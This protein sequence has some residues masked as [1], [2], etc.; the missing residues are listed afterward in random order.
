MCLLVASKICEKDD[1]IPTVSDIVISGGKAPK[2]AQKQPKKRK[3]KIFN[4]FA[5]NF[6]LIE[7]LGFMMKD[8]DL[9]RAEVEVCLYFNWEIP[10]TTFYDHVTEFLVRGC[11]DDKDLVDINGLN[12]YS[13]STP[14]NPSTSSPEHP[15]SKSV[16]FCLLDESTKDLI[17]KKIRGFCID[18]M[19]SIL[20]NFSWNKN[21]QKELAYLVIVCSRKLCLVEKPHKA[22]LARRLG[23]QL[24]NSQK[25]FEALNLILGK[26]GV[27]MKAF[28]LLDL[29]SDRSETEGDE[30]II[31][32]VSGDAS[33]RGSRKSSKFNTSPSCEKVGGS[34]GSELPGG[35][36]TAREP[37]ISN[38]SGVSLR[39]R[40]KEVLNQTKS[41][42]K[43]ESLSRSK[44]TNINENKSN[45]K[46][47]RKRRSERRKRAGN[48]GSKR[49]VITRRDGGC[50]KIEVG[51]KK[52]ISRKEDV[53]GA[54]GVKEEPGRDED[55][56]RSLSARV[57][58]FFEASRSAHRAKHVGNIQASPLE[59]SAVRGTADRPR[60]A[61]RGLMSTKLEKLAK[62]PKNLKNSKIQNL[63]KCD[64][65]DG[66][67]AAARCRH[68]MDPGMIKNLR[69]KAFDMAGKSEKPKNSLNIVLKKR[70]TLKLQEHQISMAE[71]LPE[72]EDVLDNITLTEITSES[73]IELFPK[74]EHQRITRKILSDLRSPCF[75]ESNPQ[76]FPDEILE[77]QQTENSTYLKNKIL[78]KS[79]Q[80]EPEEPPKPPKNCIVESKVDYSWIVEPQDLSKTASKLPTKTPKKVTKMS[81]CLSRKLKELTSAKSY[82]E[83]KRVT[84][85]ISK[86]SNKKPKPFQSKVTKNTRKRAARN[87]LGALKNSSRKLKDWNSKESA[88][89]G[90]SITS[91]VFEGKGSCKSKRSNQ[92]RKSLQ[93]ELSGV[94]ADSG[95]SKQRKTHFRRLTMSPA[96]N[97]I[98][99][100][101][102]AKQS[103]LYDRSSRHERPN[104]A[105]RMKYSMHHGRDLSGSFLSKMKNR[106]GQEGQSHHQKAPRSSNHLGNL[107]GSDRALQLPERSSRHTKR[108]SYTN[109]SVLVSK[110]NVKVTKNR[111]GRELSIS[112]LHSKEKVVNNNP[113]GTAHK[114]K[115]R[116]QK[117]KTQFYESSKKGSNGQAIQ[118]ITEL[119]KIETSKHFSNFGNKPGHGA[120]QS[121]SGAPSYLNSESKSRKGSERKLRPS[122][123]QSPLGKA[124]CGN[125][126]KNYLRKGHQ[127]VGG[128]DGKPGMVS[129]SNMSSID[130]ILK[131]SNLGH[132]N[133]QMRRSLLE[134][135]QKM[136]QKLKNSQNLE[137]FH[138]ADPKRSP[139]ERLYEG[140]KIRLKRG[141]T[142]IKQPK[143]SSKE[144]RSVVLTQQK[145]IRNSLSPRLVSPD[146][147]ES[148]SKNPLQAATHNRRQTL[149][150]IYKGSDTRSHLKASN[151]NLRKSTMFTDRPLYKPLVFKNKDSSKLNQSSHNFTARN[152]QREFRNVG[153]GAGGFEEPSPG[154]LHHQKQPSSY[155]NSDLFSRNGGTAGSPN[156][157]NLGGS[158]LENSTQMSKIHLQ[159]IAGNNEGAGTARNSQRRYSGH[160]L[161]TQTIR[162]SSKD[163][164]QHQHHMNG[165]NGDYHQGLQVV[166]IQDEPIYSAKRISQLKAHGGYQGPGSRLRSPNQSPGANLGHLEKYSNLSSKR[167]KMS[168]PHS[169]EH[170]HDLSVAT[171][172]KRGAGGGLVNLNSRKNSHQICFSRGASRARFDDVK[173]FELGGH[174][175]EALNVSKRFEDAQNRTS[176]I[177]PRSKPEGYLELQKSMLRGQKGHLYPAKPRKSFYNNQNLTSKKSRKSPNYSRRDENSAHPGAGMSREYAQGSGTFDMKNSGYDGFSR[178]AINR[179]YLKKIYGGNGKENSLK[180]IKVGTGCSY[181]DEVSYY[182]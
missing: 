35:Q 77:A 97:P 161:Q 16:I 62:N 80:M 139:V 179:D 41:R 100:F 39:D 155:R 79:I 66:L 68:S 87:P 112:N 167:Q 53:S 177:Q 138:R 173:A 5:S 147:N 117:V 19:E 27:E 6:F 172:I 144:K 98:S 174:T 25:V 82:L 111:S 56:A 89:G 8:P 180:Q 94:V 150:G 166:K 7:F 1:K 149:V 106:A 124:G 164:H 129:R 130:Q 73:Q 151:L 145:V 17:V 156:Y 26:F 24:R 75:K 78:N 170:S 38:R 95:V 15:K 11:L 116:H 18:I 40:T 140:S 175:G 132:N 71:P 121:R 84:S 160:R 64:L 60:E 176:F 102:G 142:G 30:D 162:S 182:R 14:A 55:Q 113:G 90:S 76:E 51:S 99:E 136:S 105:Q 104:L 54:G 120:P 33:V 81:N 125:G 52:N 141:L 29:T 32:V 118:S 2:K 126:A 92:G 9:K 178:R 169:R 159:G 58:S 88:L 157:Q 22:S 34:S 61:A 158:M 127:M 45:Y 103:G 28:S 114:K 135:D 59:E 109:Q 171:T 10:H 21:L 36:E 152:F 110:S 42:E 69:L 154:L 13:D 123:Y 49:K 47:K 43:R 122:R 23:I 86:T 20:T 168:R 107:T 146:N 31:K 181:K 67:E 93:K 44:K 108:P 65:L 83:D 153:G 91:K 128:R 3:F 96:F 37:L 137:L 48:G 57:K 131:R 101:A 143:N 148:S 163:F 50:V 134:R 133:A 4:F 70:Q 74:E 63:E 85:F 115:G 165:G 72:R 46:R 119:I 12:L